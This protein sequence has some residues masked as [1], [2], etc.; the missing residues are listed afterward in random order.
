MCPWSFIIFESFCACLRILLRMHALCSKEPFMVRR[1][2]KV[3]WAG[4]EGSI[5]A[6][7][8][9]IPVGGK[10]WGCKDVQ[11]LT[12]V[13]QARHHTL[14][15]PK[16]G[17]FYGLA[18]SHLCRNLKFTPLELFF[19]LLK[20]V[21]RLSLEF[22]MLASSPCPHIQEQKPC[23]YD[24]VDAPQTLRFIFY[25]PLFESGIKL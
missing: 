15:R 22:S 7:A 11:S 5:R 16:E 8:G 1:L 12:A 6:C 24:T 25:Q 3:A 10:H 13:R 2:Q 9:C 17:K 23:Y 4:H 19:C 20:S 14:L 18:K 21:H